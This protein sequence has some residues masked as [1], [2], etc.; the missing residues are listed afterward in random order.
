[1]SIQTVSYKLTGIAPLLQH[2]GQTSDPTNPFTKSM[3]LI[4]G[5]RAKTEADHEELARI[6]YLAGLYV[7]NDQVVIPAEVI[8]SC[9]INGAKK[10][11]MGPAAKA[12]L[13]VMNDAV[14]E[15]GEQLTPEELWES[16]VYV[17]KNRVRVQT[18]AIMRTRPKFDNWSIEF[19]IDFNDELLNPGTIDEFMG[20]AGMQVGLC[21]WR[22]RYGRF[23]YERVAA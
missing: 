18:S 21:D 4:T 9:I 16:G 10:I 13:F 5:K 12:G 11:K 7:K 8:E 23:N 20:H 3:K 1:M 17:L 22:P 19:A 14:L 15:Y 6:E 2:N